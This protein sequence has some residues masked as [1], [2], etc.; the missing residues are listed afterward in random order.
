MTLRSKTLRS[1][2]AVAMLAGSS[3]A[4]AADNNPGDK[5]NAGRDEQTTGS[6]NTEGRTPTPE[7]REYCLTAPAGDPTCQSLGLAPNQ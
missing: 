4:F 3:L 5:N 7:Q 2:L 6:I 1:L